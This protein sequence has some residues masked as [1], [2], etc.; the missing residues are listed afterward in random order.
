[1]KYQCKTAL[2]V[3]GGGMKC[4]YSA[5]VLDAFLDEGISFDYAIGVSAGA[6]SIASFLAGQRDRNRRFY[7][8]HVRDSRVLSVQNLLRTGSVFG[9]EYIYG[10]MTNEGGGDPL[11]FDAFMSNPAEMYFPAT[12]AATGQP[13]YF[14]KR[15]LKRNHY[16]PIMATCAI[17]AMCRPVSYQGKQYFDGGVSDSIPVRKA[18]SD[19]CEQI[20]AILSKPKGYRMTPQKH[21]RAYSRLLRKYPRTSQALNERHSNYNHSLVYLEELEAK[22]RALLFNPSG[23]V[24]ISTY[25][26]DPRVMQKLYDNGLAD[27]RARSGEVKAFLEGKKRG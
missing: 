27:G 18:L 5:G 16:E 3:E 14:S 21:R 23:A 2:L 8:V 4:A 15:E 11:D 6:A 24:K 22:G 26:R 1:M 10:D 12:D 13:R 7:C 9:L 19:G 20:V 25:T 17:P